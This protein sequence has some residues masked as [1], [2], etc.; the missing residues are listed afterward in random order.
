MR[1]YIDEKV[2]KN[3]REIYFLFIFIILIAFVP[4][5]CVVF[6]YGSSYAR[7]ILFALPI[8]SIVLSLLMPFYLMFIYLFYINNIHDIDTKKLNIKIRKLNMLNSLYLLINYVIVCIIYVYINK[9]KFYNDLS[10]IYFLFK[11]CFI[12]MFLNIMYLFI[13]SIF[14]LE[15]LKKSYLYLYFVF[16]YILFFII[17]YYYYIN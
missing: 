1:E 2:K 11:L 5:F 7:I 14:K 15:R 17:I 4:S 3:F 6:Y 13:I 10:F 12:L 9:N 8:T 16:Y